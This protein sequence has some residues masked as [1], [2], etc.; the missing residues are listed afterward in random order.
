[1]EN[2]QVNNRSDLVSFQCVRVLAS[3]EFATRTSRFCI[4]GRKKDA[5]YQRRTGIIHD[6]KRRVRLV[7]ENGLVCQHTFD[8]E[9]IVQ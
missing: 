4:R 6:I 3:S 1:M 2:V 8:Y 5:E 9:E 7:R